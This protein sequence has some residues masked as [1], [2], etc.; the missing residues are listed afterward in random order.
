MNGEI[1]I[2]ISFPTVVKTEIKTNVF[3]LV[4]FGTYLN[5]CFTIIK[6]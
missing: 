5:I 6:K 2:N 1:E 4:V 3:Q